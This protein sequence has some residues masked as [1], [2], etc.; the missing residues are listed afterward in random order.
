MKTEEIQNADGSFSVFESKKSIIDDWKNFVQ[1][2]TKPSSVNLP[3]R[4][5]WERCMDCN[6]DPIHGGK[7]QVVLSSGELKDKLEKYD[8]YINISSFYMHKIYN[9]I[10]GY[11]YLLYLTD[12]EANII[13]LVGDDKTKEEF[14]QIFNFCAG[15][16]WGEEIVGTTAVAIALSEHISVPYISDS[17]YCLNLK[18]TSCSGIP[19]RDENDN[20][21][22]ILGA[23]ANFKNMAPE[24]FW[25][26]VSAQIGI[27]NQI[28]IKQ[29]REVIKVH[30]SYY[31]SVFDS[32]SDA[33]VGVDSHGVI[34]EINAM[35]E[36]IINESANKIIGR[37][38][39]DVLKFYPLLCTIGK[40]PNH[41]THADYLIDTKDGPFK[42]TLKKKI[43]RLNKNG[44][45]DGTLR[46][47]KKERISQV[48]GR[49]HDKKIR[50]LY[51]FDDL[52]GKSSVFTKCKE[53][54]C[55]A[56]KTDSN[57]LLTGETGTGKELFAQAIHRESPRCNQAFIAVNCGAIPKDLIESELFGYAGGSFTGADKKGRPGKFELADGGTIFLDEIGEMSKDL[58]VRL[59]RVLQDGEVVRIGGTESALTDV[60]VIAATN[61]DIAL[62]V[63]TGNFRKDLY[64]RLNVINIDIPPLIQRSSDIS[65]LANHFISKHNRTHQAGSYTLSKEVSQIFSKYSW[66]GNVRELENVIERALVFTNNNIIEK[67]DLPDH[68][69]T[70]SAL[71]QNRLQDGPLA[72]SE[73]SQIIEVLTKSNFNIS[74]SAKV[75]RISRNTLYNKIEKYNIDSLAKNR[76]N[77]LTAQ[78]INSCCFLEQSNSDY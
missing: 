43:Q 8:E 27:E 62:E 25:M 33:I 51:C 64:W 55:K 6:V 4:K 20:V 74:L 44:K 32:V 49:N 14:R 10:K 1:F 34:K 17:K 77:S 71:P 26:L 54:A 31:K 68:L 28:R 40:D 21:F 58:Q 13:Y 70:I 60:R 41:S 67:G 46:V 18:A 39:K 16:S 56:S 22:G 76:K 69:Q 24:V 29:Q 35:A 19:L 12:N 11:G 63:N 45:P 66:P 50:A 65:L 15:A 57:I 73:K 72:K 61:K 53:L 7:S 48:K 47:I 3:I 23:A 38:V 42:Y 75:L 37:N 59:L 30:S 2:G 78:E 52:I 5:S 36:T 9:V